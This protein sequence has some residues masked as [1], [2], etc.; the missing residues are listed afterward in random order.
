VSVAG[1]DAVRKDLA[2]VPPRP[3]GVVDVTGQLAFPALLDDAL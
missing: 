2:G 3:T 1:A